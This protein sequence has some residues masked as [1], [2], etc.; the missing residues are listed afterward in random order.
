MDNTEARSVL[1][2]ELAKYRAK[3]Y[4]QLAALVGN[5]QTREVTAPSGTRY[6][7]EVQALWDDPA[8]P[9][10]VLRIA[11]AIDDGGVRAYAPLTDAFLLAPTG[12]F[13]GE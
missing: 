10:G 8:R 3:D 9:N 11:G 5:P 2:V 13:V 12:E 6:Q 7:L 4:G 1:R